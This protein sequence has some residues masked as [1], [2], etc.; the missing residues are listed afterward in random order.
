MKAAIISDTHF[1]DPQCVLI[2]SNTGDKGQ[3]Y[4][5]FKAAAGVGN[6]FLV[7][8]GDVFDFS[9][10]PY[11]RAYEN[12]QRFFKL[13]KEEGIAQKIIYVRGNHDFEFWHSVEYEVNIIKQIKKGASPRQFR[14]SVPG[15]L[16]LR[17]DCGD[18]QLYGVTKVDGGYGGLFL[19]NITGEATPFPFYVAYPNLYIVTDSGVILCTHGHYLDG[20]WAF[21]GELAIAIADDEMPN[22]VT[23]YL[24]IQ[25]VVAVNNPLN[26]LACSGIGQSGPLREVALRVQKE[27]KAGN[28]ST[29]EKFIKKGDKYADFLT[30]YGWYDPREWVADAIG[31]VVKKVATW[32]LNQV[33]NVKTARYTESFLKEKLVQ[34]RFRRYF[35]SCII[36]WEGIKGMLPEH[37]SK[38]KSV[39]FGHTHEPIKIDDPMR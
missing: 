30:N 37:L 5:D 3:K 38:I 36:E 14:W 6:D 31:G 26:Q 8:L 34:A 4:E 1:G 2:N 12:A 20:Y 16:D 29:I 7:L 27:A 32:G 19:D 35:D 25:E 10:A 11:K 15:I 18:F 21:M 24:N 9:I 22:E 13:V 17:T 23:G 39:V 28:I 33:K